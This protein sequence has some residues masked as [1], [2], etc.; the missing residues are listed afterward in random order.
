MIRVVIL[1]YGFLENG[2]LEGYFISNNRTMGIS[3]NFDGYLEFNLENGFLEKC[4]RNFV[5]KVTH[6]RLHAKPEFS[7]LVPNK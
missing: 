4:V 6:K 2:N 1:E 7:T 5:Y 3:T